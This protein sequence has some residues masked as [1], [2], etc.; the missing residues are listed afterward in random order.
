MRSSSHS[1]AHART[2]THKIAQISRV[3]LNVLYGV[4]FTPVRVQAATANSNTHAA[5]TFRRGWAR[6]AARR[7]AVGT[8]GYGLVN[9][10]TRD[11]HASRVPRA[12]HQ[13]TVLRCVYSCLCVIV[14]G[15][16]VTVHSSLLGF[17]LRFSGHTI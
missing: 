14:R 6:R 7:A 15:R 16:R 2:G 4:P 1:Q 5:F 13:R 12:S 3:R 17:G 9:T 8:R 11:C 10:L